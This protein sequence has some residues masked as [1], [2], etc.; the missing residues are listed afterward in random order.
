MGGDPSR[1]GGAWNGYSNDV[2]QFISTQSFFVV[3]RPGIAIAT[4]GLVFAVLVRTDSA[5]IAPL[6]L[7]VCVS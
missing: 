7:S 5:I 4:A 6:F 1:N 3:T 2:S